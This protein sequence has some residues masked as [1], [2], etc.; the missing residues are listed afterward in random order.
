MRKALLLA[1]IGT[2]LGL[3]GPAAASAVDCGALGAGERLTA[4]GLSLTF[5]TPAVAAPELAATRDI[6]GNA[7]TPYRTATFS[8]VADLAPSA[9]ALVVATLDWETLSDYDLYVF[10]A[11]GELLVR[12]DTSNIDEGQTTIERAEFELLHCDRISVVVR[13]WAG[14][15]VEPLTLAISVTPSADRL[16][17]G[18]NDPAP[19]CAGKGAGEPPAPSGPDARTFLYLGG[20]PGQGSMV[21]NYL[22]LGDVVPFRGRL[23]SERPTGGVPN[24]HTRVVFGFRDQ[25]QNPFVAHFTRG[26]DQPTDIVGDVS[27]LLWLSS[28]TYDATSKLYVDLYA[29]QYLVTS[30]SVSP[31]PLPDPAPVR[32]TLPGVDIREA[33]E[34]ALQVATEPAATSA[35][36]VGNPADALTTLHYGSVQ[37]QS[38]VVLP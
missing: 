37:F 17:C 30:V 32:V 18:E 21:H 9:S 20:D 4:D 35:P 8:F 33:T 25:Y 3:A 5:D 34:I 2:L 1:V 12:A 11:D 22:G 6:T 13:N 28:P 36:S 10:D 19:G 14:S 24:S 27:V 38:R 26:L 23:E 31:G 15:P 16:A 7:I 29:D